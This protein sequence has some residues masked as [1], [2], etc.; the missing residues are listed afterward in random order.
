MYDFSGNFLETSGKLAYTGPKPLTTVVLNRKPNRDLTKVSDPGSQQTIF[1]TIEFDLDY[2]DDNDDISVIPE[3]IQLFIGFNSKQE[4]GLRSILQ[5]FRKEDVDFTITTTS[6]NLDEITFST[7]YDPIAKRNYAKISL[8]EDSTS[9]FTFDVD[10]DI[11]GLKTG[12]HLAIFVK[13]I[14]NTKRQ[15]VS[16]NNG[17][18]LKIRSVFAREIICD[19]FKP[20]VDVLLYEKTVVEDFPKVN[21]T[22]YLS[23]RFVV[24]NREIGRFNV[25]GQTEIE[26]ERYRIELNNVGKLVAPED[27]YIFK[28]Y[29]KIGRA[30]V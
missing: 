17:Y 6:Q 11:R 7:D 30:H 12:Q 22:T 16:G 8:R 25:Y 5:L 10:G 1:N 14:T 19:F 23:C 24:W 29:D 9:L 18:L 3:P 28:E 21:Q 4:G 15:Y 2:I 20:N 26:D 27:V 13:D